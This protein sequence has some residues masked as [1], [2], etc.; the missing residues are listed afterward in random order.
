MKLRMPQREFAKTGVELVPGGQAEG[1]VEC[2]AE[3]EPEADEEFPGWFGPVVD[4][5]HGGAD[6]ADDEVENPGRDQETNNGDAGDAP[7]CFGGQSHPHGDPAEG[8]KVQ[9]QHEDAGRPDDGVKGVVVES[10]ALK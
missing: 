7:W 8:E 9:E 6:G 5:S 1:K 10:L 3:A 4:V 2:Y